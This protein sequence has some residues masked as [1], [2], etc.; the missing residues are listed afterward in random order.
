[1]ATSIGPGQVGPGYLNGNFHQPFGAAGVEG[2]IQQV[3]V[4]ILI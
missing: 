2:V 4:F 3:A 1:M